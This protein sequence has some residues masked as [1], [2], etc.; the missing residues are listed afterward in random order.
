MTNSVLRR[1]MSLWLA[2]VVSL[3]AGAAEWPPF[4]EVYG[5][6]RSNLVGMAEADLNRA[7]VEGLLGRL[8]SKVVLSRGEEALAEAEGAK[9]ELAGRRVFGQT[10]AYIRIK[11]IERGLG[12]LFR[13]AL[14]DPAAPGQVEGLVLDLRFADGADYGEAGRVADAFVKASCKLLSWGDE[15]FETT[16]KTNAFDRPVMVLVNG[17]TRRA[18]EALAAALRHADVALLIGSV[19]AGQASLFR[20]F[21]LT[22]GQRLRIASTPVRVGEGREISS[23]G[24]K[25]DIEVA[26]RAEDERLFLDDP[27]RAIPRSGEGPRQASASVFGRGPDPSLRVSEADLVR[28]KR[29][30]QDLDGEAFPAPRAAVSEAAPVVTDPALARALD[31]LKGLAV[32][33]ERP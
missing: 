17:E 29:E 21:P 7:A 16:A 24:I 31:L 13:A 8:G 4:D 1:G 20:E 32:L 25:P 23:T 26:V 19:T 15:V 22:T 30:G 3:A 12:E 27:Y 5:V 9:P 11:R 33:K 14:A 28:M 10:L 2:G 6:I 18:A